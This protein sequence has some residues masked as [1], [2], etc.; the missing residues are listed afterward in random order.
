MALCQF[1]KA[2]GEPCQA[3]RIEGSDFCYFHSP[4]VATDRAKARKLGGI[5][6]RARKRI[7][8]EQLYSIDR[9]IDIQ[10]A[11]E[12]ALND[13]EGLE[14]SNARARTIGYIC[15]MLLKA[16]EVGEVESRLEALETRV[17]AMGVTN[18]H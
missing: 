2:N 3:P 12:D 6:R 1:T 14:N 9:V 11:L 13:V 18:E 16:L 5:N 4:E 17:E 8:H 7:N 15:Q 10:K